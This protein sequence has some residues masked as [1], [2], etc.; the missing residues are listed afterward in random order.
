MV[1]LVVAQ[2]EPLQ[3]EQ[4]IV[5]VLVPPATHQVEEV[6]EEQVDILV[7]VARVGQTVQALQVQVAPEEVVVR[8]ILPQVGLVVEE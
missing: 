8:K 5:V 7:L 3:Q 4:V 6:E 1:Q 2:V